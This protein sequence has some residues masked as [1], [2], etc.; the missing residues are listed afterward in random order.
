[1]T[2][3]LPAVHLDLPSLNLGSSDLLILLLV[4]LVA[5]FLA[6]RVVGIGGGL[7]LDIVVGV[8][9]AFLGRWIFAFLGVSLGE[10]I[11]P[12][13]IVAFVGA[14][15]LLLFVRAVSGGLGYRRRYP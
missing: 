7:L 9:G 11:I 5:G 8:I 2:I 10:G 6:S 14:T 12:L 3:D 13:V 1:M 15:F 4:G